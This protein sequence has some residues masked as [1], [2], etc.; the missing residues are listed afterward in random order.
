MDPLSMFATASSLMG[1]DQSA[2][3]ANIPDTV[4]ISPTSTAGGGDMIVGGDSNTML[5]VL[6]A[7]VVLVLAM[8]R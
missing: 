8:R 5:Y 7:V 3:A 1:G 2:G 4:T 6:L